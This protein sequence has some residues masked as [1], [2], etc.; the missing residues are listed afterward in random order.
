MEYLKDIQKIFIAGTYLSYDP[1]TF[2][3][4]YASVCLSV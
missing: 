1:H 2:V 3:W 4:I